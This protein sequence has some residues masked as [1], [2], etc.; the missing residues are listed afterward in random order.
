MTCTFIH[1]RGFSIILPLV[2][3]ILAMITGF[4]FVEIGALGANP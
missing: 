2:S 3:L 1:D 4:D